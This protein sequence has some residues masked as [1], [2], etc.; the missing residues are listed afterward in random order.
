MGVFAIGENPNPG[1]P[2]W[3]T[4]RQ[5]VAAGNISTLPSSPPALTTASFKRVHH[6]DESSATVTAGRPSLSLGFSF[7]E[8]CP[9]KKITLIRI[10]KF[11]YSWLG[12]SKKEKNASSQKEEFQIRTEELGSSGK[13][14]KRRTWTKNNKLAVQEQTWHSVTCSRTINSNMYDSELSIT[15]YLLTSPAP[16]SGHRPV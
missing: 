6:G 15:T 8:N 11:P 14:L 9:G 10:G 13:T 3:R 12:K 16:Y 4:N 2:A 5:S 1:M 7:C